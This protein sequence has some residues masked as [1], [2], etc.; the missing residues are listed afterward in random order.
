MTA[1]DAGRDRSRSPAENAQLALLL[2]VAGTPK[3]GNVDRERDHGDL[4]FG[5]FL[6]GAVGAGEGLRAAADGAPVGEAFER[7]VA[8]MDRSA[9]TN[10]QFGAL[11]V[12]VPLVRTAASGDL[13]AGRAAAVVAETTVEDAAD[14]YRAFD[15]VDVFVGDPPSGTVAPDVRRGSDAIPDLR[16]A[17]LT[18]ADVL[19][20]S[21][22]DDGVAAEL[23]G[24]FEEI[25]DAADAI[26][27]GEGPAPD[28]AAGA[29]LD[30]LA[31]RPDTLVA[32]KHGRDVGEAVRERAQAARE[33]GP[34]AVARL[35]DD[36]V[37]EGVNPGATADVIAGGLFV[38]LE[39]GVPV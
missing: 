36:L 11:L 8:G 9:G 18:L 39:R 15:H 22:P 33:A 7:A 5:H 26:L 12:L 35:A 17:D 14:F 19:A 34:G 10:A 2:E 29:Y 37:A 27:G 30:L 25:F 28:R 21:A 31:R 6:A 1:G 23:V 32:K 16:A 24:G 38:A 3:P 4:R 20:E 13:T